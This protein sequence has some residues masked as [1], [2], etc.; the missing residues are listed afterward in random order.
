MDLQLHIEKFSRRLA[1]VESALSD[2]TVFDHNQRAQELSREYARLKEL[3]AL[4]EAYLKTAADLEE[5]RV[6]LKAEPQDSELAQLVTEEIARLEAAEK[7]L[8][9]DIRRGILPPDPSDSRNTI[10]E[11]R[12]G[13][14]GSE[15]A[16]FAA[17]LCR[18]YMHYAEGRGWKVETLDSSPSDLG[19]FKEVIF[20]VS[21]THVYKRLKYE[22]GVHR[23]QRV[24]A[25]EAQGRIHTSTVTVAVLPE[26][27]EVDVELK[28]EELEITVCRASGPGGQGVNTTDSAVQILHKPTGL[29]VRCADQRSQQKN[30]ARALTILRSRLLEQK[31][32]EEAA[33]YAAQRKA[34]VGTGERNERIRTYNFP[35][36]RVSDH[37]IELTLYNLSVV[38]D[39]DLDCLIEPLMAHDLEEKMAALQV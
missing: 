9:L 35:Q 21:G 4:G 20:N 19:G 3:V 7:R 26:A 8:L 24:P 5:N 38:I 22:S 17:D 36:N 23:V 11:I 10:I 37:R 32:A 28:P 1:E 34:Q 31:V 27:Q 30:K 39:G 6:L 18:M 16:L 29:I 12:A 14:G 15:S 25:T 33:K 13:A 2:P